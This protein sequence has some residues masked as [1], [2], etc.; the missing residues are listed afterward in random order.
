MAN[1]IQMK[2]LVVQVCVLFVRLA[3]VHRQELV[4][5]GGSSLQP[6]GRGD[7]LKITVDCVSF[8]VRASVASASWQGWMLDTDLPF[9]D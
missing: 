8:E 2:R 7:L 3:R 9:N 6:K 1:L 4:P 5:S